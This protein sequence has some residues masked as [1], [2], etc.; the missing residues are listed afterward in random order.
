MLF[1]SDDA[2][3]GQLLD[4]TAELVNSMSLWG[5]TYVGVEDGLT[6]GDKMGALIGYGE[7]MPVATAEMSMEITKYSYD[8]AITVELPEEAK[9]AVEIVLPN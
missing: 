8:P 2:A 4:Q 6:Y 9:D 1:R 3:M 5:I 7:S